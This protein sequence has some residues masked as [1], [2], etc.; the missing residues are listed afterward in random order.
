[1]SANEPVFGELPAE[2]ANETDPKKIAAY[3]QKAAAVAVQAVKDEA[4]ERIRQAT[5]PTPP[6]TPPPTREP[7]NA[8]FYTDPRKAVKDQVNALNLVTQDEFRQMTAG[9]QQSAIAAAEMAAQRGKEYWTRFEREIRE[10]MAKVAPHQQAMPAFWEHAYEMVLG[11][12]AKDLYE[13]GKRVGSQPSS[14][15]VT[16]QTPPIAPEKVELTAEQ[17]DIAKRL[18]RTEEQYKRGMKRHQEGA[19]PMQSLQK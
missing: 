14:E 9:L 5:P 19:W 4:E 15:Q 2:L 16:Q 7:S 17:K 1:M 11:R 3:Y 13:E 12:H 8:D 10:V 6:V 18:G